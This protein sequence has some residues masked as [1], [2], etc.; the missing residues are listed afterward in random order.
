MVAATFAPTSTNELEE[1]LAQIRRIS[2]STADA[3]LVVM[4]VRQHV[5]ALATGTSSPVNTAS[6][7]AAADLDSRS[8]DADHKPEASE[9]IPANSK[10]SSSAATDTPKTNAPAVLSEHHILT[11]LGTNFYFPNAGVLGPY[12][13]VT[14]GTAIGIIAGWNH[15]SPLVSDIASAAFCRVRCGL[16]RAREMM[17]TAI[18]DGN[19]KAV[20]PSPKRR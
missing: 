13:L 3:E 14:K 12:Y 17:E 10:S 4:A 6:V 1:L 18:Q 8:L 5:S 7:P 9:P 11:H 20:S 15:A 2:L 19:T 16:G